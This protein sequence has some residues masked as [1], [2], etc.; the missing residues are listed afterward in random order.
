VLVGGE[1]L[2]SEDQLIDDFLQ[3]DLR[4]SL[5]E[6]R[7]IADLNTAPAPADLLLGSGSCRVRAD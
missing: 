5:A 7:K 6:W 1:P 4:E 3:P 2:W